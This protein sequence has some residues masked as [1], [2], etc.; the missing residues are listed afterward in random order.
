MKAILCKEFGTPDKLCLEEVDTPVA[1]NNQVL[2]D[3]YV[4]STNFPDT[5][6]I[7]GKYQIRPPMPFIPGS[8]VAG[9]VEAVGPDVTKLKVGDRVMA[10][11]GIGAYADK[12]LSVVETVRILPA[13]MDMRAAACF[14]VVYGTSYY[15]L[16]QRAQLKQGETLLV[17]G[18][19]GGV[20]L[21]AV[22]L[23]KV[24]GARV[25]AAASSEEKLEAA[26]QAGADELINYSDG[27]LKQKVKDL[28]G[29]RGADVVYDPVGGDLF[30]QASRA[31]AWDGRILIIGF[32]SGEI[33]AYKVNLALLKSTSVVG[34]FWGAWTGQFPDQNHQNFA[35][36]FEMYEK[37]S[38]KPLIS[39]AFPLA[40]TSEALFSLMQRKAL[41]KV[42]IEMKQES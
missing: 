15:A 23:G 22:E 41:G 11:C 1:G 24:M 2:I 12:V 32:A 14:N 6:Q 31:V 35:E 33:P 39:K 18:A 25:I 40:G 26:K 17:L 21:S 27:E 4:A 30:H 20:G 7:D 28:T 5:L 34:V 13:K 16:K 36:L 9:I 38:I 42:V 8:E 3:I 37:G 29:G 10:A 19:G